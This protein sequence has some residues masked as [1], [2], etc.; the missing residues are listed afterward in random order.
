MWTEV[1]FSLV[2]GLEGIETAGEV[3]PNFFPV[4]E[5]SMI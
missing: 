2:S 5:K 4:I 3:V 1:A